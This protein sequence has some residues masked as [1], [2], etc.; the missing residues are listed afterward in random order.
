MNYVVVNEQT[1]AIVG[2]VSPNVAYLPKPATPVRAETHYWNWTASAWATRKPMPLA[3]SGTTI[4]G[5]KLPGTYRVTGPNG[6]SGEGPLLAESQPFA[7][8]IP[9]TYSFRFTT[10]DVRWLATDFTLVAP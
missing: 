8:D 1:G 6:I 2:E 7:F 4:T 9:G 3:A 5:L 10:E